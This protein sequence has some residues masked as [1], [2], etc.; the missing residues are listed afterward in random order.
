MKGT[1]AVLPCAGAG[2]RLGLPYPKELLAIG[3]GRLLI[4]ETLDL[5]RATEAPLDGVVLVIDDPDRPTV[6][7]V[8]SQLADLP[9][10][11][12]RQAVAGREWTSAVLSVTTWLGSRALVLLPDQMVRSL[13]GTDPLRWALAAL[14]DH[15]I[16]FLAHRQPDPARLAGD[17][18]L[19][20][21]DDHGVLTVD[22]YAERP[23]T[24][25]DRFDSAWVA[26]ALRIP[27]GLAALEAM[28]RMLTVRLP[29]PPPEL[30]RVGILGAPVAYVAQ[31][32]DLGTWTNVREH[33]SRQIQETNP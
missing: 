13:P 21:V 30:R 25:A 26:V 32:Q 16:S 10:C 23:G 12:V 22:G 27:D 8:T 7:Y 15:P 31:Y 18:A 6:S 19:R 33:W 29:V 14:T 20:I 4:D 17:G 28:H 11:V 24:R 3:P 5:L 1:I 9:V 2:R